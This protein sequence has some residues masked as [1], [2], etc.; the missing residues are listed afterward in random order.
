MDYCAPCRRHLNGALSCPGCGGPGGPAPMDATAVLPASAPEP[1]RYAPGGQQPGLPHHP[2]DGEP[3]GR[4]A[5]RRPA[6]RR[7]RAVL[8]TAAGL[9]LGGAGV[10]A[11]AAPD[12]NGA[13]R[14]ITAPVDDAQATAAATA[15]AVP[16]TTSAA[17]SPTVSV[18]PSRSA[19]ARASGSAT[20]TAAP[21]ASATQ[22]GSTAPTAT[23]TSK[24]T[25]GRPSPRPSKS[26]T[27]ILFWCT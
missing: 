5:R 17:P 24:P 15:T 7:R 25:H 27:P 4:R 9:A 13:A 16:A 3:Q 8:L 23:A 26:C 14:P 19:S 22:Q 11:L 6:P 10:L 20:A 18:K 21:T 12:G 2:A 1:P